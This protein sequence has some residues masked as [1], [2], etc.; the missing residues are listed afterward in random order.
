[1]A[2]TSK[3][4]ISRDKKSGKGSN[5]FWVVKLKDKDKKEE[6][7]RNKIEAIPNPAQQFTNVIVGFEFDTGTA[8]LYDLSGRQ[9][10][11]FTVESR[12]IPVDMSSYPQGIYIM[13]VATNTGTA[14]VKIMKGKN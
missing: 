14:S 1:M 10:Q 12:T 13:E 2:G 5:D 7:S 6:N 11:T 4:T 8:S 9:L 3:G